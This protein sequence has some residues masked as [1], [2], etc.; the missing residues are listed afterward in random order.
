MQIKFEAD[1]VFIVNYNHMNKC[2]KNNYSKIN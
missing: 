2:N 1:Q